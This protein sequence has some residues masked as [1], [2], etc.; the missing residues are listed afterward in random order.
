[1]EPRMFSGN[2]KIKVKALCIFEDNGDLFVSQTY[3]SIKNDN[4]YRPIGG[5][6]E[7]N[8]YSKDT[9]VREIKEELNAEINNLRL[10]MVLENI[11]TCDGLNGHEICFIYKADFKDKK[12][13]ERKEYILTESNNKKINACWMNIDKFLDRKFR[14][15]PEYLLQY[16]AEKGK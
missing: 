14:L 3:D 2:N 13:Y 1:M 8:E 4:Y 6:T 10:E 7:F 12:Y 9:I 16:Y 15:V 11:F 5:T